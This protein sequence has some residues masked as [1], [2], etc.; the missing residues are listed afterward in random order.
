MRPIFTIHAGEYIFAEE[1]AKKFKS[2]ELW[3]PVRDTGVD[4]LVTNR[5][6][7]TKSIQVKSIQVKMS[8]DYSPLAASRHPFNIVAGGW[9]RFRRAQL[10]NSK[11]DLW[12]LIVIS[13]EKNFHPYFINISPEDLLNKLSDTHGE[14]ETY[15]FYPW[16]L[17]SGCCLDGR[18][19]KKQ[20]LETIKNDPM[21]DI[22]PVRNW[23]PFCQNWD[24]LTDFGKV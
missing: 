16:I 24:Q 21:K 9:F 7:D 19:L 22:D 4:F 20:D 13:R 8:R 5:E 6:I 23:T 12:S 14:N 11:A 3:I 15:D 17:E 18:G 1:V 2:L 10:E